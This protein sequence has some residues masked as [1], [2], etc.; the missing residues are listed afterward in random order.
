M[1]AGF[2]TWKSFNYGRL[3][4]AEWLLLFCAIGL[5][6]SVIFTTSRPAQLVL[7]NQDAQRKADLTVL[8]EALQK[9]ADD[10]D[11]QY[12][13]VASGAGYYSCY[14]CGWDGAEMESETNQAYTKDNWIPALVEQKYLSSLPL[15]PLQG[16]SPSCKS[17]G[18]IYLS[19]GIGYKVFNWCTPRTGLNSQAQPDAY[20]QRPPYDGS[21]LNTQPA[22]AEPL[23]E[24]VDP[25]RPGWG[26]AIYT[27]ELACY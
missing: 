16:A 11:G 23:K 7:E 2:P 5:V 22:N 8:K 18:Y 25:A 15:D 13:P 9:Y 4:L 12:P 24:F 1:K 10:H 21:Q 20:C 14:N 17:S 27:F 3:G 6:L 26:Y 19:G